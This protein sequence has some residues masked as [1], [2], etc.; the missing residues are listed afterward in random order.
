[1]KA[2][3]EEICTACGLCA[4]TCPDVFS[5]CEDIVKVI[6]ETVPAEFEDSVELAAEECPAEAIAVE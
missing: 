5:M 1:M 6:A 2:R 3:I 4:D